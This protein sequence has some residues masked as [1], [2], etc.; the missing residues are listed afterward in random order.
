MKLF[1]I[2]IALALIAIVS[3]FPLP[4]KF[5]ARIRTEVRQFARETSLGSPAP[6]PIIV[7]PAPSGNLSDRWSR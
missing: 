2:L 1:L 5:E 4:G 3:P 7:A 6:A